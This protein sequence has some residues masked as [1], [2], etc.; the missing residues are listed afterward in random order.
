MGL[1]LLRPGHIPLHCRDGR[2]DRGECLPGFLAG[3]NEVKVDQGS[4][5]ENV[6]ERGG[7]EMFGG[8]GGMVPVTCIG[9]TVIK[10]RDAELSH[11]L[12]RLASPS[13]QPQH[14][15]HGWP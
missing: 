9:I 3:H 5:M 10:S 15:H 6:K 14:I 12:V 4:A 2:Q 13:Y 1:S 11:H 7:G 8:E